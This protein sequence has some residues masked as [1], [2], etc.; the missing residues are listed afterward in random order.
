MI[1]KS[2]L[3]K[4]I[5]K[6]IVLIGHMG[7]GKSTIGK[8]L[9]LKLG[10]LFYDS[11]REIEKSLNKMIHEIFQSEGEEV[12]RKHELKIMSE[13]L[14][15]KKCIISA[16]GGAFIYDKTRELI[17]N[18]STSL[19]LKI[20]ITTIAKRVEKSKKRPLLKGPNKFIKMKELSKIRDPIYSKANLVVET[21]NLNQTQIIDKIILNLNEY[22]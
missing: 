14:S 21:N 13:L 15:R 22:L 11:D 3:D 9:S 2:I 18:K 10:I 17:L 12:F 1:D 20:D 6:P 8:L 5:Q 7:S 19:W 4:D 16:G